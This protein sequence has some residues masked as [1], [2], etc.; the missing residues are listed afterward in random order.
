MQHT[1]Q[2]KT[3]KL[4]KVGGS[5]NVRQKLIKYTNEN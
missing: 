3:N 2:Y 4:G 1:E 5:I